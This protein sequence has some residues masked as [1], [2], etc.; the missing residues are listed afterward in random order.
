MLRDAVV[1]DEALVAGGGDL[2][3][4]GRAEVGAENQR[5]HARLT[6]AEAAARFRGAGRERGKVSERAR[7]GGPRSHTDDGRRR[8]SQT[9]R[10]ETK[11]AGFDGTRTR[12]AW[13]QHQNA[14]R[15][16][17]SSC[18]RRRRLWCAR[19]AGARDEP[20]PRERRK[21]T[22]RLQASL[23][24]PRTRSFVACA[25][26]HF[27][28]DW[29]SI[30][31]N[32]GEHFSKLATHT[33]ADR[34]LG[35]ARRSAQSA[36]PS[37]NA[38]ISALGDPRAPARGWARR[39]RAIFGSAWRSSSSASPSS[40]MFARLS[41]ANSAPRGTRSTRWGRS[42]RRSRRTTARRRSGTPRS[43]RR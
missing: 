11:R 24:S 36:T 7:R 30:V 14:W 3:G 8:T 16:V 22:S 43:R 2:G 29:I 25:E 1:G 37:H 32:D 6:G 28:A 38:I 18:A 20:T 33:W 13:S 23:F 31:L 39:R 4:E 9:G 34:E 41:S 26:M 17:G 5:L 19:G 35:R 12:E 27:S 40:R 10:N 42:T 15:T 21:N